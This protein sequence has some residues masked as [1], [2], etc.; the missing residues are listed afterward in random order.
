MIAWTSPMECWGWQRWDRLSQQWWR[1]FLSMKVWVRSLSLFFAVCPSCERKWFLLSVSL[2]FD[3]SFC[4]VEDSKYISVHSL[5]VGF[6]NLQTQLWLI[7]ESK[8]WLYWFLAT[9]ILFIYLFIFAVKC[10]SNCWTGHQQDAQACYER[11]L[12]MSPNELWPHQGFVRSLMEMGQ[13]NMALLHTTG[14]LENKYVW[15]CWRTVEDKVLHGF[16]HI[17]GILAD[18]YVCDYG[19]V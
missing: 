8:P 11:A 6:T 4:L 1:R 2:F 5:L 17:T 13:L 7:H 14:I 9:L 12:Q 10:V 15:N 19:R 3:C 16:A 18:K